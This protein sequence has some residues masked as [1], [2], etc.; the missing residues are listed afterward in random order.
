M[1]L[2]LLLFFFSECERVCAASQIE[3]RKKRYGK[4]YG[5]L[6]QTNAPVVSLSLLHASPHFTVI[7]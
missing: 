6:L 1:Q 4:P 7:A 2:V 3:N 5:K